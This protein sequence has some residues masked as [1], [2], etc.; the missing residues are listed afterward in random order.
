M[1][2]LGTDLDILIETYWTESHQKLSIKVELVNK[3]ANQFKHR[4]KQ[5]PLRLVHSDTL[6]H[7]RAYM[8]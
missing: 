5:K 2:L 4:S 6:A 1:V 7:T 3:S 8:L